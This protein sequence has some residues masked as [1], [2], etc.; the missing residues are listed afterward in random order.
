MCHCPTTNGPGP[1]W[2]YPA[3]ADQH[4]TDDQQFPLPACAQAC[5][6]KHKCGTS[7]SALWALG[8]AAY[9]Q[10]NFTHVMAPNSGEVATLPVTGG[11]SWS[12]AVT[13]GHWWSLDE[14]RPLH[15]WS[16]MVTDGHQQRGGRCTEP[17]RE[18]SHAA[19]HARVHALM[20][21]P[22]ACMHAPQLGTTRACM[23][24]SSALH[25]HAC[26]TPRHYTCMHAPYF[27]TTHACMHAC[28][29]P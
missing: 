6:H 3:S 17:Q 20:R 10:S 5:V 23:R 8:E 7:A 12:L 25:V 21:T 2:Q 27:S 14:G 11:H 26:A 9:A 19:P 29:T 1:V 24:H 16:L 28:T 4:I 22:Y 18:N 15:C 13:H